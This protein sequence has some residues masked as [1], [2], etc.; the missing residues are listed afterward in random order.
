MTKA[1]ITGYY[2]EKA[3]GIP[4][5]FVSK[6]VQCGFRPTVYTDPGNGAKTKFYRIVTSPANRLGWKNYVKGADSLSSNKQESTFVM[7]PFIDNVPSGGLFVMCDKLLND[8]G[9]EPY[10]ELES[11]LEALD[12]LTPE[13]SDWDAF[14]EA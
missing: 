8:E 1:D 2:K 5:V 10:P 3:N 13:I 11:E 4:T 9:Y 7:A 12:I 14:M 6:Q